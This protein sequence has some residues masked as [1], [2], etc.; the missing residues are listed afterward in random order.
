MILCQRKSIIEMAQ[1][2]GVGI[3]AVWIHV[4]LSLAL[5]RNARRPSDQIVPEKSFR[6]VASRFE[7]PSIE[8]GFEAVIE[9][10]TRYRHATG[11]RPPDPRSSA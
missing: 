2:H 3:E 11:F 8:E 7:P 6:A 4:P 5:E 9:I 1:R 10:D